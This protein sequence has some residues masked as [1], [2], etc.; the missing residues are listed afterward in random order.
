M[1]PSVRTATA[2]PVL[3]WIYARGSRRVYCE[4][5]LDASHCLYELRTATPGE[6]DRPQ[7][8]HFADVTPAF[9]RH[10]QLESDLIRDGWTL[11]FYERFQPTLH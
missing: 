3:R 11:E 2:A 9:L 10:V 8:E 4:L 1:T 7:V 5:T 6:D